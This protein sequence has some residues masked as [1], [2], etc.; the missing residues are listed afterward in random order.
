MGT[1]TGRD[2]ACWMRTQ[3]GSQ[4]TGRMSSSGTNPVTLPQDR[5]DTSVFHQVVE[6]PAALTVLVQ[7]IIQACIPRHLAAGGCMPAASMEPLRLKNV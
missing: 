2:L 1:E 3:P 6:K 4:Q 7:Q 5:P